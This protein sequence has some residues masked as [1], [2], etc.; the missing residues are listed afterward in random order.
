MEEIE[1]MNKIINKHIDDI[2][3][4]KP[5]FDFKNFDNQYLK[6]YIN[7]YLQK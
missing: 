1:K 2:L 4:I 7:D 5:D 3:E 6:K